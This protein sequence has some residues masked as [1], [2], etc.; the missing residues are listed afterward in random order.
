[1]NVAK[2]LFE[3]CKKD[4][5]PLD[6]IIQAV[7]LIDGYTIKN[8]DKKE[9]LTGILKRIAMGEDQKMGTFDDKL[10]EKTLEALIIMIDSEC[11]DYVIDGLVK[12]IHKDVY[13]NII[14]K[15]GVVIK[16]KK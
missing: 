11:I 15:C 14:N 7:N 13:K 16:M 6:I 2:A 12:H 8:T 3:Y 9:I 10:S 4:T 5:T 1:M